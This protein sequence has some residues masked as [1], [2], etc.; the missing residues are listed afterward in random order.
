MI[1]EAKDLT[2]RFGGHD[3]VRGVTLSVPEGA[4][5]ALIGANGAGKTTTLRLLLDILRADGGTSSVLGKDSTRLSPADFAAIGYVSENQKLPVRLTVAQFFDYLRPLY[6]TW[7]RALEDDLRDRL[8][9]PPGRK[10]GK[11]SHGMRVKTALAG[12]LAFRPKVLVLDEPLSGLDPL[13]RDEV[14]EGLLAQ[15]ADMTILISSHELTEIE[16]FAS[17]V[18]YMERGRIVFQEPIE[19]L[20]ARFR[21]VTVTFDDAPPPPDPTWIRYAVAG[22]AAT[23]VESDYQGPE[24]LA[25]KVGAGARIETTPLSLKDISKALMR[26]SRKETN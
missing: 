6:P 17:H 18:A 3:A 1:I 13:V 26:A 25:R 5:M 19:A 22:H 24:A 16:G 12:A 9:L 7:D 15:A 8:D 11:L 21:G 14:L 20:M 23:F 4:A 10:V 2:K